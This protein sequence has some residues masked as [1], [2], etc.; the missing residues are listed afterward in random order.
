MRSLIAVCLGLACAAQAQSPVVARPG[1][2][3]FEFVDGRGKTLASEGKVSVSA[4]PG[5]EPGVESEGLWKLAAGTYQARAWGLRT[6]SESKPF[7]QLTLQVAGPATSEVQTV[8]FLIGP[9]GDELRKQ[10]AE[11]NARR[12]KEQRVV[13]FTLVRPD[14]TPAAGVDVRCDRFTNTLAVTDARGLATCLVWGG[15]SVRAGDSTL[16]VALEVDPSATEVRA[17]LHPAMELRAL[18]TGVPEGAPRYELTFNSKAA[19]FSIFAS[20]ATQLVPAVPAE[21][22]IVCVRAEAGSACDVVVPGKGVIDA[23]LRIGAPGTLKFQA[24]AAGSRI[25]DPIVYVDRERYSERPVVLAPGRHVLVVN[26]R[27]SA[28]RHETVFEV[29]PGLTTDLQELE[30]R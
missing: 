26:T 14:G 25:D 3:K 4:Q 29:N 24:R 16:G 8:R 17:E 19:R 28:A 13:T 22:T 9:T 6:C 30:L 23:Q 5:S 2:V 10:E 20:G 1:L 18:V 15:T 12:L 21:R 7:G 11:L 27:S